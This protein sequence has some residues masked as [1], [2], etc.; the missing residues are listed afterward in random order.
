[1]TIVT[2]YDWERDTFT[3][4]EGHA[5]RTAWRAAV[6]EVA[7][8]SLSEKSGDERFRRRCSPF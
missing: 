2:E 1:M 6:A 5:A 4:H 3:H 7:L 8:K